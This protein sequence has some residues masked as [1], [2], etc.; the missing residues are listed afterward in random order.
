MVEKHCRQ[1]MLPCKSKSRDRRAV[2][3]GVHED[4][5]YAQTGNGREERTSHGVR[6]EAYHP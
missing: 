2:E 3:A 4:T 5:I 6:A 1:V